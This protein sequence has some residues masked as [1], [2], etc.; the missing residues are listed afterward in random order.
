M[1]KGRPPR[2]CGQHHQEPGR[3]AEDSALYQGT[4]LP[5]SSAS[6]GT[7]VEAG[8]RDITLELPR[9]DEPTYRGLWGQSGRA[10][11]AYGEYCP[12]CLPGNSCLTPPT[13]VL[14][15]LPREKEAIL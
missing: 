6:A 1:E 7:P 10:A 12:N 5:T 4:Y 15:E 11:P 3:E 9:G 13:L 14:L 8:D 2:L